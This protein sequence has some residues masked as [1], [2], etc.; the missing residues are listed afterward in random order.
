MSLPLLRRDE[1]QSIKKIVEYI[2]CKLSFTLPTISKNLVAIDSRLKV[3]NEYIDEQAND[4]LF[5]GI[6]GMGGMGKTTVARVLYDR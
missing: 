6:C 2:Q 1:S 3:L 4:T 5:I